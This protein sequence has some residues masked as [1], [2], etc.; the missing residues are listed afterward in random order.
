M[1]K[2]MLTRLRR[3]EDA[4]IPFDRERER[5]EQIL[6]RRRELGHPDPE[7][8]PLE[9]FIGCRTHA[10]RINRVR[11]FRQDRAASQIATGTGHA[12]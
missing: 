1:N 11:R 4:K 5:V 7:P 12:G 10:D 9:I 6:A 8:V 3:L 2:A